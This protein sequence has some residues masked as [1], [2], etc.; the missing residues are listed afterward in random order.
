MALDGQVVIF[1][2]AGTI[3]IKLGSIGTT[4]SLVI[5]SKARISQLFG[6]KKLCGLFGPFD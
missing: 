3:G 4:P 1:S 2:F 5:P 6:K